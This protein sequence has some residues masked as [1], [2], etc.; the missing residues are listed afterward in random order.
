MTFIEQ[1]PERVAELKKLQTELPLARKRAAEASRTYGKPLGGRLLERLQTEEAKVEKIRR[2][3]EE[4]SG[5][6]PP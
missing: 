3:I 2:R 4:L 5:F 1:T 6:A